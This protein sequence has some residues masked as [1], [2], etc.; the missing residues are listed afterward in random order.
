MFCMHCG[1][2][3]PPEAVF[4]LRC[5]QKV[6]TASDAPAETTPAQSAP[7]PPAGSPAPPPKVDCGFTLAIIA[8]AVGSVIGI[9]A[10]IYAVL[11]SN[12]VQNGDYEGAR[13]AARTGKIWSWTAIIL[14][15]IALCL[16]LLI[17]SGVVNLMSYD[18]S[19][20]HSGDILWRIVDLIAPG[21]RELLD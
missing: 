11:A 20:Q 12:M 8:V 18:Q 4:C 7:E 3:L 16:G 21:L 9:V 17:L 2:E 6:E 5:G 15:A 19:P 1:Q 14:S 10:L 13:R